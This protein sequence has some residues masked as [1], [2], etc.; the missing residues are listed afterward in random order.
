MGDLVVVENAHTPEVFEFGR[1]EVFDRHH[2]VN[3]QMRVAITAGNDT[4]PVAFEQ[5]S[6]LGRGDV[7]AGRPGVD[8]LVPVDEERPED[9]VVCHAPDG[10]DGDRAD[11]LDLAYLAGLGAPANERGTIDPH[12]DHCPRATL[13]AVAARRTSR[14]HERIGVVRRGVIPDSGATGVS[15]HRLAVSGDGRQQLGPGIGGEPEAALQRAV[16]ASPGAKVPG[17]VDAGPLL[18]RLHHGAGRVPYSLRLALEL[19]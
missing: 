15:K 7:A 10:G 6:A 9:G 19:A 11:A 1:S 12:V 18:R 13:P 14:S 3:L 2:V 17:S 16:R 5:C 4:V 8:D